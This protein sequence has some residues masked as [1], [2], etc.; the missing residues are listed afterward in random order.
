MIVLLAVPF[1][2]SASQSVGPKSYYLALGDSVAFGYQPNFDWNHGYTDQWFDELQHHGVLQMTNYA[3]PEETSTTFI[4]GGCSV[5]FLQRSP[6][7]GSQLSAAVRFIKA[8]PGQVSPVSLDIGANDVLDEIDASTCSVNLS[9]FTSDLATLSFN[10]NY[11]ILPQLTGALTVANHRTGDLVLML[12]YNPY[13]NACP[14]SVVYIQM[15]NNVI[16]SAATNFGLPTADTYTAFS[17]GGVTP[18]PNICDYTW[19]CQRNDIHPTGGRWGE[20]GNGYGVI[21]QSFESAVGY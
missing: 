10:L 1:Q 20:P 15:L 16:R 7:V 14:G 18:N 6:H 21:A 9:G 19:M 3:C 5:W 17:S 4:W 2:G 11:I 12:Y 13:Q 8:H